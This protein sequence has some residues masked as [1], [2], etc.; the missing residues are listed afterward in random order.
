MRTSVGSSLVLLALTASA[1]GVAGQ[2]SADPA[3]PA[4]FRLTLLDDGERI[5]R[6]ET[7]PLPESVYPGVAELFALRG[8]VVAFQAVVESQTPN[9]RDFSVTLGPFANGD[10]TV[11]PRVETFAE[12]FVEIK[13]TTG[14]TRGSGVAFRAGA[15]P[16]PRLLGFYADALVPAV[17]TK[18]KQGERGALWVDIAVPEDAAPGVY[19]ANLTV[20][21]GGALVSRKVRLRVL[22][23]APIPYGKHAPTVYY[24]PS[25]L[26]ARM[27]NRNAELQMRRLFHAHH[28]AAFRNTL[29]AADVDADAPYL[30]GEAYD[31]AKGYVGPGAGKPEGI[32]V[33]GAY[34]ELEDADPQKLAVVTEMVKKL[35]A[36]KVLDDAYLDGGEEDFTF[37]RTWRTAL[38]AD[39]LTKRLRVGAAC[40]S[41]PTTLL[42]EVILLQTEVFGTETAAAAVKLGKRVWANNGKRP[43]GGAMVLDTPA[44]DLRA[45]SWISAR[46]DISRW[47]YW[48]AT[49]WTQRGGGKLPDTNTDPYT[50]AESFRN[51]GGNFSNGD[52]ILVYPGRQVPPGMTTFDKDEVFPSV[53]L[54]NVRR[55]AQDAAYVELA[56]A[57]DKAKADAVVERIVPVA[58]RAARGAAAWP[59]RGKDYLDARRELAASFADFSAPAPVEPAA[60]SPSV[61]ES[62]G[63]TTSRGGA[64]LPSLVAVGVAVA[65]VAARRRRSR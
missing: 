58:M 63:C 23:G 45:N 26:E 65:A 19:D 25:N 34:G 14:G 28:V 53:R 61:E 64:G 50:V 48:E 24:D 27:G 38:D 4:D 12:Q 11:S 5:P 44:T 52:G 7:A 51:A 2:A 31:P 15:E 55:G 57:K 33:I 62:S 22:D 35:D 42:P 49:S 43:H 46:Y 13:R 39:P 37:P 41:D 36:L 1:L 18:A 21:S 40:H 30:T 47:V 17:P 3:P 8:E 10:K 59:T 56:R 6:D 20:S 29:V 9:V 54:K 16:E 60:P 32:E